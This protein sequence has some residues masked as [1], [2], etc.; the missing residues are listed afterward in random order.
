MLENIRRNL[1]YKLKE[2]EF[3]IQTWRR[4][5]EISRAYGSGS[6]Q[7]APHKLLSK[8]AVQFGSISLIAAV[9][10][11]GM[12]KMISLPPLAAQQTLSD[13]SST[14]PETDLLQGEP[15]RPQQKV[16]EPD[17]ENTEIAAVS[18]TIEGKTA[19]DTVEV[20]TAFDSIPEQKTTR[21]SPVKDT[22][23][24][25]IDQILS[26]MPPKSSADFMILANKAEKVLYLLKSGTG[27]LELFR[28]YPMA[29]GE[30][31]GRKRTSGDK[32]TPEGSYFIIGRKERSELSSIYGPI[33]FVL[34]YPNK[35]DR[36]ENRSGQGIWIHG[37]EYL[38]SPPEYTAGC[39]ALA[40]SDVLELADILG[41]GFA[42]PVVIISGKKGKAH[43]SEID[44]QSLESRRKQFLQRYLSQ[45]KLLK[46]LVMDW[47]S[48]WESKDIEKYESFYDTADFLEGSQG[49]DAFR[50][51][52]LRTFSIYDTI[53]ITVSKFILIELSQSRAVVKFRQV[54]S[55]NLNRMVNGKRLVFVKEQDTWKISREGTFP[56]EELLL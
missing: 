56:E 46:Q 44:L 55:T 30:Q 34:N 40:N 22:S 13:K 9:T 6:Q 42:V 53:D 24:P 21:A 48:A 54:Y 26:S 50:A 47:K 12:I 3:R 8:K 51:R 35:N 15:D 41:S 10:V 11:W 19:P 27:R 4:A 16:S 43:L 31:E 14:P 25:L 38:D 45:E 18:D 28:A 49:W 36:S 37:S 5:R 52:K 29:S 7:P 2:L 39:L 33:A 23:M 1:S 20:A 32:K 17:P